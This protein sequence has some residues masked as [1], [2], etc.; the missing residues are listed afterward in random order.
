M[1]HLPVILLLFLFASLSANAQVLNPVKWDTDFKKHSNTEYDLI[2]TAHIQNGWSIYSQYLESDDGPVRTS[3][4]FDSGDHFELVGKNEESGNRKEGYDALFDMNV[5][6]FSKKAVFT[7]RVKVKDAAKSISGYLEFMTCDD[8]RCLPPDQVDF[9]FKIPASEDTGAV[10]EKAAENKPAIAD[11]KSETDAKTAEAVAAVTEAVE[12]VKEQ[13]EV[14]NTTTDA[15][16]TPTINTPPTNTGIL[17]PVSWEYA[18]KKVSDDTYEMSYT[19]KIDKGWYI[20]SQ[21]L[22][23]EDGPIP[24][25]FYFKEDANFEYLGKTQ[26]IGP[27]ACERI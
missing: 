17:D 20:Y 8:T 25:T 6:K 14:A 2:F 16:E 21:D 26:R 19:A 7:Q 23:G 3:F 10:E 27:T 12:K 1:R 4:E 22:G 5:I 18:I 13:D 9:E 15:S 24:T 11:T